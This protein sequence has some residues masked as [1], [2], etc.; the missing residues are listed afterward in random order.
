MRWKNDAPYA[1]C[2]S[3]DVDRITKQWY[4][5]LFYGI[6][7]PSIQ[8]RSFWE[9]LRGNEPYWNFHKLMELE[10]KYGV[11]STFFFLNEGHRELSANF[12]GRYDIRDSRV[13]D[14]IRELDKN[15][16]EIGLHGSYY[17][18]DN[19]KLL[20]DE[21]SVLEEIVGHEVVSARQHHLNFD[22]SKTWKIQKS[23]GIKYDSTIGQSVKIS[24][25]QALR[26]EEDIVELP[27]TLM[28]TV[29][30]TEDIYEECCQVAEEEG[31]I[32]LN[33]HQCHFNEIEYPENVA[34]YKR[35]LE[36][37]K[38]DNAWITNIRGAGEWL[39]KQ[40]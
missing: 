23:I 38:Q 21:K 10:E 22:D 6:K 36:K 7:N 30:L 25:E 33:F 15:G 39:D 29:T 26:T 3:H 19:E 12:M 5:Y 16:F 4:H 1:L 35:L 37:A 34:L 2:L 13:C 31:M 28:D 40:L 17:S 18:F 9:K 8:M 11:K 27:I 32:V 24:K 14:I 20:G